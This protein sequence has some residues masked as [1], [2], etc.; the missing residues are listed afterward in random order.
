MRSTR[1]TPGVEAGTQSD[2]LRA[3]LRAAFARFTRRPTF[4]RDITLVL[5]LKLLLLMGLKLAFFDHPRAADMSMPPAAVAQALLSS[6]AS[7]VPQ[8]VGHAQ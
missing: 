7:R 8:G 1:A 5:T 2:A 6:P 4:A 3:P